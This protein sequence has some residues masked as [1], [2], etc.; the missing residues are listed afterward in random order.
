MKSI[1]LSI[2]LFSVAVLVASSN[3][4]WAKQKQRND[5]VCSITQVYILKS[6][7]MED[8]FDYAGVRS[9][10]EDYTWLK[11][12]EWAV[13]M[14]K[15]VPP[16]TGAVQLTKF[17]SMRYESTSSSSGN[18]AWGESGNHIVYELTLMDA[19]GN[20]LWTGRDGRELEG[21]KSTASV[22]GAE[23][24]EVHASPDDA[25]ERLAWRL[26]REARCGNQPKYK[27]LSQ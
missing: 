1:V 27:K 15:D 8:E 24:H 12:A 21:V 14:P 5:A 10:L 4:I 20:V 3:R 18:V 13:P 19:K 17:G 9:A 2:L 16:G 23:A 11:I 25:A 6:D 22:Y 7:L 26:N